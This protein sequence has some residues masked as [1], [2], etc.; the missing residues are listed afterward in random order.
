MEATV[1]VFGE[2][3]VKRLMALAPEYYYK[4]VRSWLIAERKEF[5][6][7]KSGSFSRSLI[8]KR[9]SGRPG[10]WDA[11]TRYPF[12]GYLKNDT[13]L[14]GMH[15]EMGIG[16]EHPTPFTEGLAKMQTG[17]TTSPGSW[18]I[19]PIYENLK[20]VGIT[21]GQ[22]KKFKEMMDENR[23]TIISKRG[24]LYFFDNFLA[25]KKGNGQLLWVG[26]RS[27]T[28]PKQLEF[29]E[30]W[31]KQIPDV[32]KRGQNVIDD[33]TINLASGAMK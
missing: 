9:R 25:G 31:E 15:M 2:N 5:V 12:K 6:G 20:N 26:A 22:H 3:K 1:V 14:Q 21:K 10:Y 23:L 30:T 16:L 28:V 7:G 29:Y 19:L 24:R 27:I 4:A 13:Q 11:R 33:C 8:R 18:M 32:L 17:Y